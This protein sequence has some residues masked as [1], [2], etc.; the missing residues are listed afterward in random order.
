MPI[1]FLFESDEVDQASYDQAMKEL[2]LA[3][4]GRTGVDGSILHL[5]GPQPQGGWRVV[6]VW[7]SEAAAEAFYGSDL[8]QQAVV[9]KLPGVDTTPWPVHRLD[10]NQ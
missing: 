1:A 9:Q 7:E 6:D 4:P 3:E 5:A 10:L 2:D 8:F